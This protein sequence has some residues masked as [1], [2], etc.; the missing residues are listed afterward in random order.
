[1]TTLPIDSFRDD[2]WE[3]ASNARRASTRDDPAIFGRVYLGDYFALPPS[4]MHRDLNARFKSMQKER[5]ARLAVAAPRGYAKSTTANLNHAM[6]AALH[7]HEKF[8]V[9]VSATHDQACLHL[10][11]IRSELANNERIREDFFERRD[12]SDVEGK[13]QDKSRRDR[14][15]LPYGSVIQAVGAGQAFRGIRRRWH[16]P[17]L[18]IADDLEHSEHVQSAR[19]RKKLRKWF[20]GTLLKAGDSKTN[21]VM[22]GTILH[23]DSLLADLLDPRKFPGWEQHMYSAI[24]SFPDCVDFWDQWERIY[25]RQESYGPENGPVAAERF[26]EGNRQMMLQG[27]KLLWPEREDFYAM[28]VQRAREGHESFDAEK[29]NQPND[30]SERVISEDRMSFWDDEHRNPKA[31]LRALT[32]SVDIIG[33]CDPSLGGDDGDQTA[34]V[35]VARHRRSNR[36]Y[37]LEADLARRTPD[38]TIRRIIEWARTYTINKFVIESNQFQSLLADQLR[39][40]L[41]DARIYLILEKV[42]NSGSKEARI[43]GLEPL[44]SSGELELSRRH[45]ELLKQLLQFPHSTYDDGPDALEMAVREGT[46]YRNSVIFEPDTPRGSWREER[47]WNGDTPLYVKEHIASGQNLP[48]HT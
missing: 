29:Q 37:V 33:A 15:L 26:F 45:S 27:A 22:I 48:P 17:S 8:I 38:Q 34:I 11:H 4:P 46:H 30:P 39:K 41:R 35:I 1:M 28:M 25:R 43:K 20:L 3:S 6:W 21:V 16:R 14:L 44:I 24:M 32:G 47:V 7:G 12:L 40:A 9:I 31:L 2:A 19:Q 23:F 36:F 10:E 5:G 13:S 42:R 18:I